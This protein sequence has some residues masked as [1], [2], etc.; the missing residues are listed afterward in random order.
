M[1]FTFKRT[2]L[3]SLKLQPTCT[4]DS[5]L[6]SSLIY[7]K[8]LILFYKNSITDL[9]NI[10]RALKLQQIKNIYGIRTKENIL[11]TITRLWLDKLQINVTKRVLFQS[12]KIQSES[13]QKRIYWQLQQV[14]D[15]INYGLK[16]L[17]EYYFTH[18]KEVVY[19]Q[20]CTVSSAVF[21]AR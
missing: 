21:I 13:E 19:T 16:Q 9:K 20:N 4:I 15:W 18:L 12:E 6:G 7:N 14:I 5:I 17:K 8:I 10:T 2:V 1:I 3:V 11:A